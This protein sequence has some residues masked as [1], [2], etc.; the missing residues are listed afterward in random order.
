MLAVI[1]QFSRLIATQL[2]D[3]GVTLKEVEQGL[4]A[5][6]LGA[7]HLAL[8]AAQAENLELDLP[9]AVRDAERFPRLVAAHNS[10]EDTLRLD[11]P[12]DVRPFVRRVLAMPAPPPD[13][14]NMYE[15]LKRFAAR[16]AGPEGALGRFAFFELTR[17]GIL[18]STWRERP[19][20]AR[21]GVDDKLIDRIAAANTREELGRLALALEAETP[22]ADQVDP[23]AL[24]VAGTVI[25]ASAMHDFAARAMSRIHDDLRQVYANRA[26]LED[27]L[28]DAEASDTVLL[29]NAFAKS[30]RR[31]YVETTRIA[32][33]HPMVLD[34]LSPNALDKRVSRSVRAL[35]RGEPLPVRK[36]ALIDYLVSKLAKAQ[37]KTA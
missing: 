33:F 9:D 6:K 1:D 2:A 8:E 36:A 30:C 12:R 23:L 11:V 15:S 14:D 31:P 16:Q 22:A 7:T 28:L 10:V 19:K 25:E 32:R 17:I 26:Q 13:M 27:L 37:E 21:Y 29:R 4:E 18:A 3:A 24:A 5:I 20:L 35:Q 34:G